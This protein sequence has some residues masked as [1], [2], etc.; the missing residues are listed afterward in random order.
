MQRR[1]VGVRPA[2]VGMPRPW[3]GPHADRW[4]LGTVFVVLLAH[5]L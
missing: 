3:L 4:F 5:R 2:R 1:S